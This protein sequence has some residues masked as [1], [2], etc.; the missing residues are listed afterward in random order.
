MDPFRAVSFLYFF[1]GIGIARSRSSIFV[2]FFFKF[3]VCL[4]LLYFSS[5]FYYHFKLV[6]EFKAHLYVEILSEVIYLFIGSFG[7]N[8]MYLEVLV[9]SNSLSHLFDELLEIDKILKEKFG[10]KI[11]LK[12]QQRWFDV[13]SVL[14]VLLNLTNFCIYYFVLNRVLRQAVYMAYSQLI[15]SVIILMLY[16]LLYQL[17]SRMN[18]LRL[19]IIKIYELRE[20]KDEE[21]RSAIVV[22]QK[23]SGLVRF[24]LKHF[25][26]K[27]IYMLGKNKQIIWSWQVLNR[28]FPVRSFF[29]L[30]T[31]TFN[32]T[33]HLLQ[34]VRPFKIS[35]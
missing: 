20:F 30:L 24:F 15:S 21:V 22:L 33:Y 10:I 2:K 23:V 28:L 8:L 26:L 4:H 32:M 11:D 25:Q 1:T 18:D 29:S 27:L 16:S 35:E 6:V 31:G 13:I 19:T 14:V 17:R 3:V 34:A 7:I 5:F 12:A 9:N